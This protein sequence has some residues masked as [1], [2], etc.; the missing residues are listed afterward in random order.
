MEHS[1]PGPEKKNIVYNPT[2][3]QMRSFSSGQETTTEYG[4]PSYVTEVRSRIADRTKNQVD[5]EFEEDFEELRE[6]RESLEDRD[7]VCV[8]RK[9]GGGDHS[10]VCRYYVPKEHARIALEWSQLLDSAVREPD[11]VTVQLPE[12]ETQ[13]VRIFPSDGVT[14]VLGSDYSGEAKKSFLRLFM[15]YEKMRGGLGLHAGSKRVKMD[16]GDGLGTVGQLFLGLSG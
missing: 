7:M 14:Y 8:D 2:F 6:A 11:F 16:T 10:Y 5:H 13:M 1:F 15:Y 3:E 12:W 9:V 4:S